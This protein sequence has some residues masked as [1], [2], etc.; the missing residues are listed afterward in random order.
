MQKLKVVYIITKLELGGAQLCVL[1]C[2][3]HLDRNSFFVT[4][5]SSKKGILAHDARLIPNTNFYFIPTLKRTINLVSDT[6][7]FFKL[8]QYLKKN[9]V[10][11]VHTHSSKAGI[12]GRWA[13]YLAKVPIILHTIHGFS[14]HERQFCLKKSFFIFLEK[15]TAKI[16]SK[17]I[18]VCQSDI[19]KGL[20]YK[21]GKKEQYILI[22]N[23]INKQEFLNLRQK[24]QDAQGRP[25]VAAISCLKPQKAPL[26]Y[27]RACSIVREV[28]PEAKFLLIGDGIL[29]QKVLQLVKFFRLENNFFLMGWRRDIP[30]LIRDIDIFVL[31]SY[32][33][34]LPMSI[35]EAFACAKPVVATA[36][37]GVPEIV[38]DGENGFLVSP[39]DY[40]SL[41]KKIIL[42][43]KD[44]NLIFNM[45]E[46][47]RRFIANAHEFSLE[48]SV[49]KLQNFYLDLGCRILKNA[50]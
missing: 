23:G 6:I 34:G 46:N 3:R 12:L 35:L 31:S 37:D 24:K 25:V 40:Q 14:F 20:K 38:K 16:T 5:I 11:I 41:A 29:R 36:V 18:T 33:E 30:S 32:W 1:N 9:R 8:Y 13:A 39:G 27:I 2:V 21:I 4:L 49:D 7:T 48:F 10:D 44:K 28:F 19:K 50:V 22:R 15:I 17:L 26:D 43:L 42:L 45:G 47:N